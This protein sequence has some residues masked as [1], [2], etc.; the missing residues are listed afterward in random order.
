[1]PTVPVQ[2]IL[3][4]HHTGLQADGVTQNKS[5][6]L[7]SDMDVG[8]ESQARKT[9]V[10]VPVGGYI[11]V[12]LTSKAL[13]S[14]MQ[15]SIS[16]FARLGLI[17]VT[18][19]SYSRDGEN[20]GGSGTGIN[21]NAGVANNVER[22]GGTLRFVINA[23]LDTSGMLVGERLNVA[24]LT[25]GYVLLNGAYS[26]TS[27][28][29][30]FDFLG[31]NAGAALVSV[32]S[33]GPNIAAA[34]QGPGVMLTL[35]DGM[36]TH[37]YASAGNAGGLGTN[38]RTYIA[39]DM[40]LTGTLD[41]ISVVFSPTDMTLQP[42]NA[43]GV[44]TVTG[45]L[46]YHDTAGT[47]IP[48][49][50]AAFQPA[51]NSFI[52]DNTAP[53][54][55][56]IAG[57]RYLLS[58]QGGVPNLD[59]DGAAASD[60]VEYTGGIWIATP[61]ILGMTVVTEDTGFAYTF[62]SNLE[63]VNS[64]SLSQHNALQSIQGGISAERY[65]LTQ[66]QHDGLTDGGETNLHSHPGL[67]GLSGAGNPNLNAV[68]GTIG[69][70]YQDTN[71]DIGYYNGDGTATGWQQIYW[72]SMLGNFANDAT[73]LAFV[74]TNAWDT[75]SNG[76]GNPVAGMA[77]FNTG[78]S[79]FRVWAGAAWTG[80]WSLHAASHQN[81]G[82]D[83]IATGTPAG[84]AIPKAD[85]TGHLAYGWMTKRPG[86]RT[87]C[88]RDGYG[89]HATIASALASIT[90]N[91]ADHPYL[92][93]LLPGIYPEDPFTMK[94]YVAIATV[95]S[96]PTALLVAK[97]NSAHFITACGSSALTNLA[98]SGPTNAGY[99]SVIYQETGT[100]AF[101]FLV[102]SCN[103]IAGYYGI[104]ACPPSASAPMQVSQCNLQ[105]AGSLAKNF[106]R[107]TDYGIMRC[108]N[109]Y[110]DPG[111]SGGYTEIV[112]YASG[113]DALVSLSG[114]V[115]SETSASNTD[116]IYVN[117]GADCL[118]TSTSLLNGTNAL[119]VGPD[120]SSILDAQGCVITGSF[121]HDLWVQSPTATFQFTGNADKTRCVFQAGANVSAQFTD[122]APGEEGTVIYGE[123]WLGTPASTIPVRQYGLATYSTGR[124][125][126]DGVERLTGLNVKIRAGNGY[127]NTGTTVKL[128]TWGIQQT[129]LTANSTEWIYLDQDGV[130]QHSVGKPSL[131]RNI[132]IG[133]AVTNATDVMMLAEH[134]S[135]VGQFIP[136]VNSYVGDVLGPL[137]QYGGV[138]T[139]HAAP[140][141][142]KLDATDGAYFATLAPI[143]F[144]GQS[145]VSFRYWRR[146]PGGWEVTVGQEDVDTG[147]YDGGAGLLPMTPTKYKKDVLYVCVNGSG[148][149][150]HLV[151]GQ[152]QFDNATL[153]EV[154][155][156]PLAPEALSLRGCR[157]AGV[158]C[159]AGA[160]A[161]NSTVD[162]RPFV[163]QS[164][165][166]TPTV[167][168][169]HSDLL[170]LDFASS[171][172]TG[173]ETTGDKGAPSGYASLDGDTLVVQN[174]ASA[175]ATP[176]PNAIPLADGSGNL[177]AWIADAT[178]ISEGI[179]QLS[180][181]ATTTASAAAGTPGVSANVSRK[182]HQHQVTVGTPVSIGSA[183]AEGA[184][185][186]LA[187]S[188]HVHAHGSQAGGSTHADVIAGGASGFMTGTQ[189]TKLAGI[190]TGATA[191]TVSG[192]PVNVTKAAND[193]G[194][195]S[196]A[197]KSDHKHDV[198][199]GVPV[200]VN[201]SNTEGDATTLARSNHTHAHGTHSDG[202]N[203]A[204]VI[205]GGASGFMT[206]T[207]ATKLAGIAAGA[208]NTPLTNSAPLDVTKAAA[209]VGDSTTAAR[210]NHKHDISTAA[211][212]AK[213]VDTAAGEGSATTM[214]RSD[215][216]HQSNT[217][218]AD[219]TA[220]V[221]AI[222]TST[223]PARA[224]HKHNISTGTPVTIGTANSAGSG[225]A[226]ALAN[227]VHDH[228]TLAGGD[229]HSVATTS[230]A[231]FLSASD[232]TKLDAI[233]NPVLRLF[234]Q[235][236]SATV[237]LGSTAEA[238]LSDGGT[239]SVTLPANFFTAGKSIRISASGNM[240]R[241]A[242]NVTIRIRLGG[243]AGTIILATTAHNPG[244]GV[245]FLPPT[246]ITCRVA[247]GVGVG[248]VIG[249]GYI[250]EDL[251]MV[252][253][254]ALAAPVS[255]NTTV[256]LD[257]A[258]T[259]Q[260]TST[261]AANAYTCT[262]LVIESV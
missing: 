23:G 190:A 29:K 96:Y 223:E 233:S 206:G 121:A 4:I 260:W 32:A 175:T 105:P 89:D 230:V 209:V 133:D 246:L 28:T 134:H 109:V 253:F 1:M 18:A 70:I 15:G 66:A 46:V 140:S 164:S 237:G 17:E 61:P 100:P 135:D 22:N 50:Q 219:V 33:A 107:I 139:K 225:T 80:N 76:T 195:S 186:T 232:K 129:T 150:Y 103:F 37:L 148:S 179:V 81:G 51:V 36:I 196:T 127:V 153:A 92:I 227:H 126:G 21:L 82:A 214:A 94:P 191:V 157:L 137:M 91:D 212:A 38:V 204:A 222:G 184:A 170:G 131:D 229:R 71:T 65:H 256:T 202:T 7:I 136:L 162:A 198:S 62:T 45:Q 207:Q 57:D 3:R 44:D 181:D 220:A 247:G 112:V 208:T 73:A 42:T 119:H 215:H 54:P 161:I 252:G 152:E 58:S 259:A 216:W 49:T 63:W 88:N 12:P 2:A 120:G 90:D 145:P 26:I 171:N 159:L 116:L 83:E 64:S 197:A 168:V 231:G 156:T 241:A 234:G 132:I 236:G 10:Y 114:S 30:G 122:H 189:A 56:P 163:G 86:I 228:G 69:S 40:V 78:S 193:P 165:P 262:N 85:S 118:L 13:Y 68:A 192:T 123:L 52:T 24:G 255:V 20:L 77:Y 248:T 235:S 14:V 205:A 224:D 95:D 177:T 87:V 97:N 34:L 154:G 188:N 249:Q 182:D 178:S 144:A 55:P 39:G 258:L 211:P 257:V 187:R 143:P 113:P 146:V 60:I 158:V 160:V 102:S 141:P 221:A 251:T 250:V 19:F 218:P 151:Y 6:V 11:D 101:A 125:S 180:D 155:N 41:P 244:S 59:W 238:V 16:Q 194:T 254:G 43:I 226:L 67:Y 130:V 200:S 79:S 84:Y 5:S 147:F 213:G 31:V 240:N 242:G 138:V 9:P 149:E 172:H 117:D 245:W 110:V 111:T 166:N 174:P 98:I 243:V 261:N 128:I 8:Y 183:N 75:N 27:F 25:G 108:H 185:D 115:L 35:P 173:F 142:L 106:L 203:H 74:R 169:N 201:T 199:T 48:I 72:Q 53:P 217:A 124:I 176:T 239:G 167:V 47:L 99:A 93:Q 104:W 210:A